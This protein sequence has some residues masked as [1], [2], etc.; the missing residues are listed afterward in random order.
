MTRWMGVVGLLCAGCVGVTADDDV[1]QFSADASPSWFV[2]LSVQGGFAPECKAIDA[3]D[4]VQW[5]NE[6]PE[7]P[8]D[9]TSLS[10]P[11]ELYSPNLQGEYESWSHTFERTGLFEYYNTQSGDPGR[12]VVDAYYG[13]V[14]YVGTS[15][16]TQRG[17]VCVQGDSDAPCCCSN[18]DCDV[19][20]S[21]VANVCTPT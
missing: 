6:D 14:T 5:T 13:T 3:G 17:V 18:L 8:G 10:T 9:V 1:V 7:I 4:T 2:S 16:N 20:S 15:P 19:G 11:P 12:R 21:C